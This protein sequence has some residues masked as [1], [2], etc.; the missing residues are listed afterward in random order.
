MKKILVR[1]AR[2]IIKYYSDDE[3]VVKLKEIIP[4]RYEK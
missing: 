2:W 3:M 1:I 4:N